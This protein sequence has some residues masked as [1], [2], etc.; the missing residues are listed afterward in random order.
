MRGKSHHVFRLFVNR[1]RAYRQTSAQSFG[2]SRDVGLYAVIL[3]RK[4]RTRPAYARLHLVGYKKHVLFVTKRPDRLYVVLVLRYNAAFALNEL[5]HHGAHAAVER[6]SERVYIAA[7]DVSEAFGKRE[8]VV[9]EH[10]LSRRGERRDRPA[11][12]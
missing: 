1:Y 4:Q 5:Y 2:K 3:A 6:V 8:K 11:V 12:E 7:F 9:V 10:V